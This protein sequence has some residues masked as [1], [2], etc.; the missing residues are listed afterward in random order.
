MAPNDSIIEETTDREQEEDDGDDSDN[1]ADDEATITAQQSLGF[2]SLLSKW[3][4]QDATL[5]N[6]LANSPNHIAG[7]ASRGGKNKKLSAKATI[8]REAS[9]QLNAAKTNVPAATATT[10]ASTIP[11]NSRQL[12]FSVASARAAKIRAPRATATSSPRA[13]L[14]PRRAVAS[15]TFPIVQEPPFAQ[16]PA[17]EAPLVT[18]ETTDVTS[19]ASTAVLKDPDATVVKEEEEQQL[20][21]S[22]HVLKRSSTKELRRVSLNLNVY[23]KPIDLTTDFQPPKFSRSKDEKKLIRKALKRNFVFSDLT[24]RDLKPLVSAFEKCTFQKGELI[25]KQGDPG[26]YFY[27][28]QSGK[29][30]FYVNEI[31]VGKNKHVG[32]SFGELAL[33]YTSPRA[34]TVTAGGITELFRVDQT[35]FRFILQSQTSISSDEK[36]KLLR[37]VGFL[38]DLTDTDL[39][40]LA[41]VMTPI[42]F[43]KGHFL[44]KKGDLGESFYLVQEGQVLIK[45]IS[46]GSTEYEDQTLGPGDYFGERSLATS[47]PRAAN[48]IGLTQGI[49]FSIDRATF[50][51]VLGDMSR[52]ILRAQDLRVLQGIKVI[53]DAKLDAPQMTTLAHL[54]NDKKFATGRNILGQGQKTRASIYLVREGKVHLT[55]RR[56]RDEI[57]EQ[58]G[59]FGQEMMNSSNVEE[60]LVVAPY[61]VRVMEDCVCGVLTLMESQTVFEI[62]GADELKLS[63]QKS[64]RLPLDAPCE[65]VEPGTTAKL[66]DL[67]RH[68]ILGEGNFGQVWL[69]S[70]TLPDNTRRPYAL[71]IQTKYDLVQESQAHHV[72]EEKK[73]MTKMNHP[74]IIKLFAT[75]QDAH[76]LYMLEELVQGGELFSLMHPGDKDGLPEAQARFYAVAIADALAYMHRGKFVFRDLKPENILIDRFGYPTIIDFGFAKHV[77]DKT[78]TLCG[79][80]GYLPPEVVMTRG[81]NCSADHWSIGILI[82]EMITGE[83]P[84]YCEGM[85]QMTLFQS[86]VQDDY[87]APEGASPEATAIISKFLAKD[88]TQRL[89]SLTR[90]EREIFEQPWFEEIDL[91]ALR[92]RQIEAP[93][94]PKI[95][96]A[97]DTRF[98]DDW[99]HLADKTKQKCDALEPKDAALFLDF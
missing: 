45:D 76:F 50:Q 36:Q 35:T 11:T 97:F 8:R 92:H 89:G 78:Y 52:L 67:E 85:D 26:D 22:R 40:K 88:P 41:Q 84:F 12:S 79:T 95:R 64:L 14:S 44:V 80:P 90:G 4:V 46:V 74:F 19:P 56:G 23:Q 62:G 59:Y 13:V 91:Q 98:F 16:E 94:V 82:Y 57:I 2:Q 47:E 37:S 60:V 10:T 87:E 38:S 25:I 72:V 24:D 65:Q 15:G 30:C 86:I 63:R 31:K 7:V 53:A 29:V 20:P 48:V 21:S 70:E 81:H 93:W 68:K 5:D 18:Q 33:L 54:L 17:N 99:G 51:K 49:A 27:I 34:T 43:E 32:S 28:L 3:K 39:K 71:K 55:T 1:S 96:D 42:A 58:G 77:P 6:N 66:E 61:T 73:T 83:N 69:V 9:M 75:Y